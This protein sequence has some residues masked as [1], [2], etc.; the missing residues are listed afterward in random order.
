MGTSSCSSIP[1]FCHQLERTAIWL[2]GPAPAGS[3]TSRSYTR[4][5]ARIRNGWAAS[6]P[7][8]SWNSVEGAPGSSPLPTSAMNSW[9]SGSSDSNSGPAAASTSA[10]LT[11]AAPR[12]DRLR[13][14]AISRWDSSPESMARRS[15]SERSRNRNGSTG[16]V[17][18]GSPNT[19][20]H[21]WGS[22]GADTMVAVTPGRTLLLITGWKASG[23]PALAN[24]GQSAKSE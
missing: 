19:A 1:A 16:T 17:D 21:T 12:L 8:W 10:L 24:V 20:C 4:P 15:R 11:S 3:V 18:G 9:A 22:G 2:I 7:S 23:G 13:S 14:I 5:S 6:G